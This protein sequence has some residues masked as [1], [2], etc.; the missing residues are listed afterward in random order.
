MASIPASAG[1]K[2]PSMRALVI[3]IAAAAGLLGAAVIAGWM[4]R[5]PA[6]VQVF[7]GSSSMT[8]STALLFLLSAVT[9]WSALEGRRTV[10]GSGAGAVALL[11]AAVL[12]QHATGVYLGIDLREVQEWIADGNP[13]PGRT[14]ASTGGAF[15]AFGAGALAFVLRA[16]GPWL[17]V[18]AGTVVVALAAVNL[19]GYL[20]RLEDL[21]TFLQGNRMAVHTS[22]G[23]LLLGAGLFALAQEERA[24]DQP[25]A[26]ARRIVAIA[27]AWLALAALVAGG[28][29]FALMQQNLQQ[30]AGAMLVN[31]LEVRQRVL[32]AQL[33]QGRSEVELIVSQ[34]ALHRAI[35]AGEAPAVMAAIGGFVGEQFGG[36][37]VHGADGV[38]LARAGR[39]TPS[40]DLRYRLQGG[41][42]ADPAAEV[43][44]SGREFHLRL[45]TD[46]RAGGGV[47]GTLVT[48]QPM[49]LLSRFMRGEGAHGATGEMALCHGGDRRLWCFPQRLNPRAFDLPGED[50]GGRR[51]PMTYALEGATGYVRTRDYR[52]QNVLAAHGPVGDTG[53]GM[54]MKVD[55]TELFAPVR[56]QLLNVL[57]G[58]LLVIVLGAWLL[59]RRVLPLAMHLNAAEADAR[60]A[61]E[62]MQRIADNVPALVGY[63]DAQRRYRFANRAYLDWFGFDHRAM[64]GRTVE[65]VV[66]PQTYGRIQAHVSRALAGE[67]VDFVDHVDAPGK[68]RTLHTSYVPDPGPD[69][70]TQGYF[71]LSSDITSAQAASKSLDRALQRLD[72]A[73]DA[74]RVTV[75]ESDLRKDEVVLS[76]AWAELLDRPRGETVTSVAELSALV[77]PDDLK[78]VTRLSMETIRGERGHYTVEHRVRSASGHWKWI[79]SRGQVIERDPATGRALRMIGTNLDITERKRAE[80]DME[81]MANYDG[82]TGAVNRSLFRDR[83]R[84]AIATCRRTKAGA[85]LMYLD[86]DRFK[87]INDTLGHA[88]GDAL[89][90]EFAARLKAAVRD[91]DTVG[92]L[93]GDEF[94]VLME[95]VKDAE[96]PGRVAQKILEAMR[97]P[98]DADGTAVTVTTS[99]GV[100]LFDGGA[101]PEALARRADEALYAAKAAGRNTYRVGS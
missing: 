52:G 44:A 53:L 90:R 89:L 30:S 34:P 80:I 83:L 78:E 91:T 20:L 92:R 87:G 67:R 22:I 33:A 41:G 37:A 75:W 29:V 81:R 2:L 70:V 24:R 27:I 39:F 45:R 6:L 48:E 54:V 58:T 9:L 8:L 61:H 99:I 59:R 84:R 85:A 95:D 35:R 82:L 43:L 74:S 73:L 32:L 18:A 4:L 101:D 64:A 71:V 26:I 13:T 19:L 79:L 56:A 17:P 28:T 88:A 62:Q 93:G 97:E 100:A 68:G 1:G 12:L 5:L 77:H 76:D 98:V 51:L 10:A 66:G 55:T 69:G 96:A 38:E 60:A 49:A 63:V 21:F 57:L 40:V 50:A 65:E 94:A 46:I 72:L 11:A 14:A 25:L 23:V 15:L 86:I 7:P 31:M 36:L 16:G 3:A 47:I 42:P